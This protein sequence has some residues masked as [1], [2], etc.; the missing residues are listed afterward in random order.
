MAPDN[1]HS[2]EF[3]PSNSQI[4]LLFESKTLIVF[5]NLGSVI[6]ATQETS[7]L[8]TCSGGHRCQAI[9]VS[10]ILHVFAGRNGVSTD[11]VTT[12][13]D[14]TTSGFPSSFNQWNLGSSSFILE[15][16][17]YASSNFIIGGHFALNN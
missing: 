15:D 6:R 17:L 8:M 12:Y 4:A 5:N 11:M 2:I 10:N 16:S 14:P 1:L 13:F 9:Y 3:G 7:G